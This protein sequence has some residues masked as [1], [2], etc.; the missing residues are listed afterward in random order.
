MAYR[1]FVSSTLID[2]KEHRDAA[3]AAI[4]QLGAQDIAMESF[5]ARDERPK[6]ECLRL[7][8]ESDFF[9][10]IYAHRYGH[11]PDGDE[12]SITEAEYDEASHVGLPRLIYIVDDVAPWVPLYIDRDPAA[13][14]LAVL[15]RRLRNRHICNS[16]ATPDQL[17][18]HVAVDLGREILRR[19][20][21]ARERPR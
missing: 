12:K 5:G 17:R 19:E 7:I 16:F 11:V 20:A 6:E 15:K 3:L 4:R 1:V 8:R 10:G 13:V 21:H 14:K 9:V 2:L 18:A